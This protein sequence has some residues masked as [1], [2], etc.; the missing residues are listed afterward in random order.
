MIATITVKDPEIFQKYLAKT[1]EV[2]A[3]FG[4]ELLF[5]GAVDKT[6]TGEDKDH[7]LAVIVKFPSLEKINEWYGSDAYRPLI[8]LRDEGSDMKMTSYEILA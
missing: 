5:R 1:Q 3:P 4:A 7:R 6:L 2:A 8:A